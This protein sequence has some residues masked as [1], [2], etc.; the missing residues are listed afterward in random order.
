MPL[1][2]PR[3]PRFRSRQPLAA[4]DLNRIVDALNALPR[5]SAGKGITI[6]AGPDGDYTISLGGVSGGEAFYGV[7]TAATGN[8]SGDWLENIR[9]SAVVRGMPGATITNRLPDFGR[10]GSA[11]DYMAKPCAVGCP[12]IILRIPDAA[13]SMQSYLQIFEGGEK[14]ERPLFKKCGTG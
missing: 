3:L 12:C 13:G 5:F 7:I 1:S 10:T 14:G 8:A 4:E 9:Y 11:R 6:H 2:F